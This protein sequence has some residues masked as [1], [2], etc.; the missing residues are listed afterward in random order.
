MAVYYPLPCACAH[1]V[2]FIFPD[3][4]CCIT[5]GQIYLDQQLHTKVIFPPINVIPSLSSLMES[6][7]GAN[8]TLSNHSAVSNQLHTF[9]AMVKDVIAMKDVVGEEVWSMEDYLGRHER[10]S[11]GACVAGGTGQQSCCKSADCVSVMPRGGAGE[12]VAPLIIII[13]TTI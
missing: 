10:S 5:E 1:L 12:A 3:L 11:C 6:A 13:I 9:Y 4:T 7:I 2:C 8:M